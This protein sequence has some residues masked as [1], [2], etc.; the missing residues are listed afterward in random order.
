MSGLIALHYPSTRGA[1]VGVWWW[2]EASGRV[3]SHYVAA[4][5]PDVDLRRQFAGTTG[6]A[7][8][9]QRAT[10]ATHTARAD[11]VVRTALVT[12]WAPS[13]YLLLTID[14]WPIFC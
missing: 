1:P 7:D 12:G 4:A 2:D 9:E 13:D 5:Y 14:Q 3:E 10:A 6:P 8:W 11:A